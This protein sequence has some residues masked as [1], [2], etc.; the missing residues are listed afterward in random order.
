MF[1]THQLEQWSAALHNSQVTAAPAEGV[2]GYC[3]NPFN[4]AALASLIALKKR[5]SA[6]GF[7]VLVAEVSWLQRLCPPLPQPCR[8]AIQKYWQPGQPPTTLILPALPTLP[9]NLTGAFPTLAVRLP[10]VEYMQQYLR[11]F[12][13]PLVSTSLNES[14]QPPATRIGQIPPGIPALTLEQ[15]LP[16]TPSRIYNPLTTEWLRR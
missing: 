1:T 4:S 6:K 3:A 8:Q 14:G 13:G 11:A 15:P 16:G 9:E 7:I 12:G 10:Q 2:Y 5:N